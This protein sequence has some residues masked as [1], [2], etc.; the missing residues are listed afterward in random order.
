VAARFDGARRV[1]AV[2]FDS[3]DV[4]LLRPDGELKR[5]VHGLGFYF[6]RGHVRAQLKVVRNRL[7]AVSWD[8]S[9]VDLKAACIRLDDGALAWSAPLETFPADHSV[10]S[11]TARFEL[12]DRRLVI[13][14]VQAAGDGAFVLDAD[15]GRVLASWQ[16]SWKTADEE[17]LR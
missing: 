10:C 14:D 13:A 1:L 12:C 4:C 9:S 7:Y 15:S 3:G 16:R 11:H 5:V 17:D 2:A 8:S 6:G